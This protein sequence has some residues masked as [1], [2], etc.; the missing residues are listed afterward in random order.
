MEFPD[1]FDIPFIHICENSWDISVIF[2]LRWKDI[3]QNFHQKSNLYKFWH[4]RTS[5][6]TYVWVLS[7]LFRGHLHLCSRALVASQIELS[8]WLLIDNGATVC[9]R[10]YAK[11]IRNKVE[12]I[13]KKKHYSSACKWFLIK[14]SLAKDKVDKKW[15]AQLE[16]EEFRQVA[17]FKKALQWQ[18]LSEFIFWI[19]G[20]QLRTKDSFTWRDMTLLL[21]WSWDI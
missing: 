10:I 17:L 8:K 18:R 2:F 3:I 15:C 19:V 21:K 13:P 16:L 1:V 7:L 12:V 11:M 5:R 4:C 20:I 6:I 9:V 14:M